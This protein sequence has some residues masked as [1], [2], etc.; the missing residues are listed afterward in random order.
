MFF[1]HFFGSY[2]TVVNDSTFAETHNDILEGKRFCLYDEMG[3]VDKNKDISGRIKTAVTSKKDILRK[4]NKGQVTIDSV[5]NLAGTSNKEVTHQIEP[6]SRR[7]TVFKSTKNLEMEIMNKLKMDKFEFFEK[8]EAE[9]YDFIKDLCLMKVDKFM[10]T[11]AM[12]TDAKKSIIKLSNTKTIFI[13][14]LMRDKK[15][16][17]IRDYFFDCD[18]P[19]MLNTFLKQLEHNFLTNEIVNDFLHANVADHTEKKHGKSS[20]KQYWDVKLGCSASITPYVKKV[21]GKETSIAIRRLE[22]FK[23]ADLQK[24]MDEL[25]DENTPDT[26]NVK[27]INNL[28]FPDFKKKSDNIVDDYVDLDFEK[29]LEDIFKD[30][31]GE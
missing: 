31:K 25:F 14:E 6:S 24:Y 13:T 26:L 29:D 15:Y 7:E 11:N 20:I 18:K 4:M 27:A 16:E 9:R 2:F 22:G 17:E 1:E 23:K 21:D 8:L 19:E 12:M 28:V 3:S 5:F 30:S 10:A